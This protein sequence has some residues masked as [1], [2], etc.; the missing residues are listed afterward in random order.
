MARQRSHRTRRRRRG[1]FR[2]LY[3]LLTILLVAAAVLV[4]CLV[5]FR[6]NGVSVE[7]NSRYT[8]DEVVAASGIQN[9]DSL[10]AMSKSQIASQIRTG[11]PYVESVA[12]QRKYPDLVVL[13]VKERSAAASVSGGGRR[14]LISSQG[15]LLEEATDQAVVEI[16][17]LDAVS[18]YAGDNMQVAEEDAATL[19]YVLDLLTV[20]ERR[21]LLGQCTTLD[22]GSNV[23]MT[24]RYG[25]YE[26]KLPRD[27]DYD[28]LIRL[29]LAALADERMP[30]DVPGTF[31]FTVKEHEVFFRAAT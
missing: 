21:E 22:C 19:G 13:T 7:G 10:V 31:D 17:G 6:V 12:I 20:L 3:Q 15:K 18:P 24:L 30:Q 25:I 8:A 14:W 11:L 29:L 28:Y 23:S 9:G 2:G 4:A 27:G 26:L 1:R 16:I 5:F